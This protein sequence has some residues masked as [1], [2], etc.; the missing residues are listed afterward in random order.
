[1]TTN[2]Q[3]TI[4]TLI[5]AAALAAAALSLAA[6]ASA[7]VDHA[8]YPTAIA[9]D[10]AEMMAKFGGVVIDVETKSPGKGVLDFNGC[11]VVKR[12]ADKLVPSGRRDRNFTYCGINV[13][14]TIG[15]DPNAVG[16]GTVTEPPLTV[17]PPVIEG[18][19]I[20]LTPA[21]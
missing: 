6:P 16:P 2:S 7:A 15:Y 10:A 9:A 11:G 20:G 8:K 19:T 4:R 17:A 3:S 18:G 14:Q 12:D 5:G 1:M 13:E 21:P